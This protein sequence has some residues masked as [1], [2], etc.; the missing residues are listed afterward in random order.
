VRSAGRRS[1]ASQRVAVRTVVTVAVAVVTVLA[2]ATPADA[3]Q[4]DNFLGD[5][6]SLL[7]LCRVAGGHATSYTTDKGQ[8]VAICRMPNGNVVTCVDDVCFAVSAAQKSQSLVSDIRA[9]GGR[10]I[11]VSN[12]QKVWIQPVRLTTNANGVAVLQDVVCSGLGGEFSA[13][14]DGAVGE[15]HIPTATVV[16]GNQTRGNNCVGFADTKKHA[17]ST[18]KRIQALLNAASG[19]AGTTTPGRSTTPGGGSTPTTKGTTP[20]TQPAPTTTTTINHP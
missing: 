1:R 2:L 5:A 16:C 8:H 20:T 7:V 15:C 18:R 10:Q 9:L 19:P 3:L 6:D 13:A 14:P 12:S 17:V 11:K 4:V